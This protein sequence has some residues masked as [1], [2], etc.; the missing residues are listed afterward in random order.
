MAHPFL[1]L[2]FN[3]WTQKFGRS[4]ATAALKLVVG[5]FF[6]DSYKGA[7][8]IFDADGTN[9]IKVNASDAASFDT[10]SISVAIGNSKVVVGAHG[11]DDDGSE[12]GSAFIYD[13]DGTNEV[14][15]TASDAA[16]GDN[17][18]SAVAIGNSKV[19]VGAK[20]ENAGG[21]A[22]G[23]AY[24]YNLDGSGEV[25]IT[26][27]DAAAND[28]FGFAVAIANN[29]VYVGSPRSQSSSGTGSVYIYNL[30]GSG[31]SKI[32]ASDGINYAKFGSSLAT[33]HDKLVVGA[34]G[35]VG[36]VYVYDLDGSNEVK[37]TASDGA[38]S[39]NF[40]CAVAIG[41]NKIVVG[42]SLDDDDGS[43]S[44]SAYVYNLD[45]TGEV[46]ITASDAAAG[47]EFGKSVAVGGNKVYVGASKEDTGGSDT[48]SI[49][50]YNLDGSGESKIPN[51]E[52]DGNARFGASMA[53]GS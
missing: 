19:A 7:A 37:I 16:A 6:Q 23:A 20:N 45:G 52:G 31:E 24:V 34:R 46:K 41:S 47:D 10:Y 15:L 26:A 5:A 17:F 8:F 50:I 53:L 3:S 30:D 13:L 4:A 32:T 29:K 49:Y 28:E 12:S 40:G 9:P 42:A 35:E 39:D 38:M 25:K 22:A 33:G 27:S 21:T 14:K 2:G 36:A 18:G 1:G 51:P 11:D 43:S 44:G 48:G